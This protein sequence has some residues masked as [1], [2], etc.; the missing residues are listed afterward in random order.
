MAKVKVTIPDFLSI[1]NYKELTT[2]DHLSDFDKLI[3]TIVVVS[4]LE[5]EEVRKWTVGSITKVYTDV[6]ECLRMEEKF[7][8]IF[9]LEGVQYGFNE[10]KNLSLGEMID[11]E[12]LC[13]D[14]TNNLSEIMAILYRPITK[15][16]FKDWKFKLV[17]NVRLFTKQMD[18]IFSHYT[19]EEYDSKQRQINSKQLEKIPAQF[20]LGALGFFLGLG[21]LFI[22][23]SLP[24]ST[25][26]EKVMLKEMTEQS[27]Q[28]LVHIGN[29]LAQFIHSPKQVYSILQEK[30]VSLN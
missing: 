21:N 24:Y 2:I 5:E 15:H 22:Q 11:L 17:H 3:K 6:I 30:K 8:P 10:F 23:S 29:G 13:Q 9:E 25:V 16:K 19:I 20:A 28:A 27:L 26:K 1:R 14:P 4:N 7:Y 18:N 12:S